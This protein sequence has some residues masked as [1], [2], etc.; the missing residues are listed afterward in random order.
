MTLEDIGHLEYYESTKYHAS[1]IQEMWNSY[2]VKNDYTLIKCL[3][4]LYKWPLVGSIIITW[5]C[6]IFEFSNF[7]VLDKVMSYID[8]QY[9]N[10]NFAML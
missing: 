9:D 10:F 4:S 6:L 5:A 1:N 8:G 3:V 2:D 7:Y